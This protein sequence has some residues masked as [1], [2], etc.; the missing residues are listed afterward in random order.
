MESF[1]NPLRQT[2]VRDHLKDKDKNF[3]L[4]KQTIWWS[5]RQSLEMLKEISLAGS[6]TNKIFRQYYLKHYFIFST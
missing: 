5:W 3:V 6:Q 4:K 1:L 2:F